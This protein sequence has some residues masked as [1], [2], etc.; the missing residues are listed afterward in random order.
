MDR[1]PIT[2]QGYQTLRKELDHIKSVERPENIKAI[3]E[4]RAHGDLSENAEFAAAKD[5]Q[6]FIES[7]INELSYKL[8]HAEIIDTRTLPKD[9]AVFASTVVLENI[10]TGE[11]VEYQLVGPEE[12]NIE[13]GRISIASPLGKAVI[14]K[15]PGDEVLL[16]APGGK[17]CYEVVEIL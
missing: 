13:L 5:R 9:R 16:Q 14:G 8:A 7:K 10:D 12:S 2:R 11:R 4:A 1:F 17:R 15:K 6:S 3:E